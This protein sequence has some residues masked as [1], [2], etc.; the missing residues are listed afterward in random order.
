MGK[1][2]SSQGVHGGG[3][4]AI[5]GGFLEEETPELCLEA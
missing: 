5:R 2:S 4:D 3:L 1:G